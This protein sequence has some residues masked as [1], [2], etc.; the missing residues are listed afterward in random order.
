[1]LPLHV[2]AGAIILAAVGAA[3][4]TAVGR[5]RG[6]FSYTALFQLVAA[7]G[8]LGAY[9]GHATGAA[10]NPAAGLK[11]FGAIPQNA[12][13][14]GMVIVLAVSVAVVAAVMGVMTAVTGHGPPH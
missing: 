4:A 14:V 1:M 6:T 8:G 3:V 7:L 13:V 5:Q 11:P 9:F 10:R 12:L 2:A